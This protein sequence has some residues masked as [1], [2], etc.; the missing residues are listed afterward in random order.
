[1]TDLVNNTTEYISNFIRQLLPKAE[2][3][4]NSGWTFIIL[5]GGSTFEIKL[6]R[7]EVNDFEVALEQYR[8]TNYFH[9]LENRIKFRIY[10]IFGNAGLLPDFD[11]SSKLLEEKGE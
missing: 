10:L 8:N 6:S 3:Q 9:T 7:G 11:I 5:E 4:V 2:V 1:M